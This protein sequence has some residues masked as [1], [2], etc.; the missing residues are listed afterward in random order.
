MKSSRATSV[1]VSELVNV[2]RKLTSEIAFV[3]ER[4]KLTVARGLCATVAVV[5]ALPWVNASDASVSVISPVP[6]AGAVM[7]TVNSVVE[8]IFRFETDPTST[9]TSDSATPDT[10]LSV[11]TVAVTVRPLRTEFALNAI[12]ATG[13]GSTAIPVPCPTSDGTVIFRIFAAV[14]PSA[15]VF[16]NVTMKPLSNAMSSSPRS[17]KPL[18]VS[19]SEGPE[20]RRVSAAVGVPLCAIVVGNAKNSS[21]VLSEQ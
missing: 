11:V 1:T 12:V 13:T 19:T 7:S 16:R 5:L 17:V 21:P 2:A 6:V 3:M 9:V 4:S 18:G 8:T 14:P 15:V 10:V 20:N